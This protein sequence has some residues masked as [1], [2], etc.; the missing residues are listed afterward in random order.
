MVA[1]IIHSIDSIKELDK[2]TTYIN[3]IT[4]NKKQEIVKKSVFN[5][6]MNAIEKFAVRD[7]FI[8]YLRTC[9]NI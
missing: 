5:N 3:S 7:L 2:I 6:K 1:K 9:F 8:V 4:S